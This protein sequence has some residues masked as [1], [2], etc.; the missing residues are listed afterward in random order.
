M[1]QSRFNEEMLREA[2][3]FGDFEAVVELLNRGVNVNAQHDINGWT[4]LHWA[5]KRNLLRI[6]EI[7]LING[8]DVSISTK[9]GDLAVQL[10]TDEKIVKALDPN[11]E[12]VMN[13]T[14]ISDTSLPMTPNYLKNAPLCYKVDTSLPRKMPKVEAANLEADVIQESHI[15]KP[16]AHLP[17]KSFD[18]F[19][20]EDSCNHEM[21]LKIRI[22]DTGD[23]DFIEVELS[24]KEATYA[25]LVNLCCHELKIDSRYVER[26]RKLPNT[27]LRRDIEVRRLTDYTEIEVVLLMSKVLDSN[28][29]S[30]ESLKPG[31][32]PGEVT[33]SVSNGYQSISMYKNQRVLY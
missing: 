1:N 22:A 28:A 10:T 17:L 24:K 19:K 12:S 7:L 33:T 23:Q 14:D 6:V 32:K 2:A 21:I 31:S 20:Q 8:A 30:C 15:S 29:G 5:S 16:C 18:T 27:I 26:I 11:K 9:T 13:D 4:A 25:N 3:C